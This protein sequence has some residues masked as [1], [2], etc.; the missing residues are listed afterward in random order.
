MEHLAGTY[1]DSFWFQLIL[2]G[3]DRRFPGSKAFAM[4]L[5]DVLPW[6]K[7][8]DCLMIAM[9]DYQGGKDFMTILKDVAAKF[10]ET[11]PA[12]MMTAI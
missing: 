4:R 10:V 3:L 8:A 9:L 2:D 12:G 11:D 6:S 7:L 1:T 5:A